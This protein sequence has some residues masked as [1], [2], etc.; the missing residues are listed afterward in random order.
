MFVVENIINND[1][2]AGRVACSL[3]IIVRHLSVSCVRTH[4]LP[5][6]RP[7]FGYIARG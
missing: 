5:A 2:A 6:V 1:R 4:P 3:S 7:V